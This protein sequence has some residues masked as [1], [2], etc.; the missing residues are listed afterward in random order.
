MSVQLPFGI[1]IAG[2]DPLD[3]RS[4]VDDIPARDQLFADDLVYEGMKIYVKSEKKSYLVV[5]PNPSDIREVIAED[6]NAPDT[7]IFQRNGT[8][9]TTSTPG[10]TLEVDDHQVN[11]EL[12]VLGNAT[13]SG[14]LTI[15]E[16]VFMSGVSKKITFTN[17]LKPLTD[18]GVASIILPSGL[19]INSQHGPVFRDVPAI[20][21]V[22]QAPPLSNIIQISSTSGVMFFSVGTNDQSDWKQ[23]QSTTF[24]SGSIYK[25][26]IKIYNGDPFQFLNL[27]DVKE[28]DY[29]ESSLTPNFKG[30]VG[31]IADDVANIY[32]LM[33]V[34]SP[35]GVTPLSLDWNWIHGY[36]IR[37]H[38]IAGDALSLVQTE[39]GILSQD[40]T[41]LEGQVTTAEGQVIALSNQVDALTLDL[42]TVQNDLSTAQSDIITLQAGQT[43]L[44][45]RVT[46]LENQITYYAESDAEST[47]DLATPASK[48]VLTETLPAGDYLVEAT[49]AI[50]ANNTNKDLNVDVKVNTVSIS[51]LVTEVV[52]TDAFEIY[53]TFK[54]IT[55]SGGVL[56]VDISYNMTNPTGANVMRIRDARLS[57]RKL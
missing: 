29:R 44:D 28:F 11:N 8:V 22:R 2:N 21:S 13:V 30:V 45:N 9:I 55:H 51:T 18:P 15:G 47:N 6:P 4:V 37:A 27:F 52:T 1:Y 41:A 26:N 39:I 40:V 23:V 32:D 53:S 19:S 14:D 17:D 36:Y 48:V 56:T 54:K 49:Y 25:K 12:I 42:G 24:T 35:D 10:D 34:Y 5:G 38:Q 57:V 16:N 3:L 50:G 20:T 31:L 7:G 43:S 46:A 33:T